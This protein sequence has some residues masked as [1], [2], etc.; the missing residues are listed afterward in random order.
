MSE[1]PKVTEDLSP[2]SGEPS[3]GTLLRK[4]REATGLHIAALAVAMKV[5]VKKLEA[6]EADRLGELPDAVFVRALAGSMCRA[7]KIDPAPVLSRLPQSVM[8][9]LDRDER[10]IN[11]PFHGSG[12]HYG[13]SL[14]A[15]VSRPAA[16]WVIGLLVAALVVLYFPEV[17]TT[18]SKAVVTAVAPVDGATSGSPVVPAALASAPAA[19]GLESVVSTASAPAPVAPSAVKAVSEAVAATAPLDLLVF[20]AKSSA[21]VRVSDAKG[22]VQFEKTLTPGE[23]ATAT[24]VLPLAIVVG[25]VSAT[26]LL[27]RGQ[28]FNLEEVAKNNVA[29]FEVK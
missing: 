17:H 26:E 27:V 12:A 28:A 18:A 9:K 25:N 8:P 13:H 23:T 6:L 22:A 20:K 2:Q 21:W 19:A 11:M 3:A 24:G 4:A 10:G 29:R 14:L 7:L 1:L 5:P 16:L 15:F